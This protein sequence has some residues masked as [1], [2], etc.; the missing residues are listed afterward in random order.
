MI[1][2]SFVDLV[3]RRCGLHGDFP[4]LNIEASGFSNMISIQVLQ[5]KD[6][7]QDDSLNEC[8]EAIRQ[9]EANYSGKVNISYQN[10]GYGCSVVIRSSNQPQVNA[11]QPEANG[12]DTAK[13]VDP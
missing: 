3:V 9:L 7:G 6:S 8:M 12:V 11:I 5:N 1:L 2:F 4:E 13:T 10:H